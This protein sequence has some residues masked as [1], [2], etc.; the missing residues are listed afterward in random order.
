LYSI[1]DLISQNTNTAIFEYNPSL[2]IRILNE[3]RHVPAEKRANN[4]MHLKL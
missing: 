2:R 1:I 4:G 3:T